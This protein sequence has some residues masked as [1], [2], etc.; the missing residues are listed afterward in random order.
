MCNINKTIL[1]L[2]MPFFIAAT[3]GAINVKDFGARGD[4]ANDDTQSIISAIN[5][6]EDGVVNFPSGRYRITKTVEINLVETGK[7]GLKGVGGSATVIM[8][9]AGPAFKFIG[10]HTKGSA[11]PLTVSDQVWERERMPLVSC[12]EITGGHPDACGLEFT[13]TFQAIISSV[14]IREVKTGIHLTGRNRNIIIEGCH[15]Y[16]CRKT[17]I[18]LDALNL[19]QI[20]ISHCHI[21]YNKESGI[22]VSRSEIRN[23]QITGNDIE[24]NYDTNA[25]VSA[26]IWIDCSEKGSS[27]REGTITGNTIQAIP[28][29]G[30]CNLL[31]EGENNNPDKIG[32][33][34][35]SGNHISNQTFNIKF[36]NVRGVSITGNTF[37][38]GFDRHILA[39][40]CKNLVI[41]S[42]VFDRNKDYFPPDLEADGG[43]LLKN[44]SN[45][46]FSDNILQ[47]VD[48]HASLEI[49]GGEGISVSNC[50]LTDIKNLG[51]KVENS[52][53]LHINGCLLTSQTSAEGTELIG[54]IYIGKG[55]RNFSVNNNIFSLGNKKGIINNSGISIPK[56]LNTF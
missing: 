34:N 33:W 15:I 7:I 10:S 37:I 35:I 43:V 16:D 22:K 41:G 3:S 50:Q 18:F 17:G 36:N 9:G 13:G 56:K 23:F 51:I 5:N 8:E 28:S 54:G 24:Y 29:P 30:G 21:S 20:N 52:S 47:G 46:V 48:N 32:L 14:F 11:S 26:D 12:I 31:F 44:I 49:E 6:A 55:V 19:H 27:V 4:G 42:N 38:R 2:L 25:D 1:L 45:I 40:N 53:K 39:E